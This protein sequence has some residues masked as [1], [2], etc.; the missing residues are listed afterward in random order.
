[1]S[2]PIR[3]MAVYGT[4]P[5]AVKMAPIIGALNADSGFS[6]DVVVTGQHR[7]ML[8]QINRAFG[9]VPRMDLDIFHHGQSISALAAKT[10]HGMESVLEC[11]RPD[12]VLVQGDTTSALA[13]GLAAFYGRVPVVHVEAGLRTP[14]LH[15]P[16]P[17]EGNR[18]LLTRIASLHLAA[19]PRN[20]DTLI[21]E[22]VNPGDIVVTGNPVIDAIRMA[23]DVEVHHADERVGAAMASGRPLI[24]VTAHRRE[25]WGKPMTGIAAAL[26]RIATAFPEVMLVFPM[27]ANPVVRDAFRPVLGELENVVLTEPLEYFELA[28]VLSCSR[29]VLTDSGG[30]QEEAPALGVPAVV[31]RE[32]TERS[33][34]VDAGTA[35]LVGTDPDRIFAAVEALLRAAPVPASAVMVRNPYGDGQAA[36][37]TVA[38]LAAYFG[39]GDRMPDFSGARGQC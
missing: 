21:G 17:E 24:L 6:C 39:I 11:L 9:V 27:H 29:L 23:V 14:T 18:R 31:L 26:H 16:F 4:R 3:V 32:E 28:R 33:E 35:V 7:D 20:R 38:A 36:A 37:R 12:A 2:T 1:M 10:L 5:E 34:G 8:D 19:T 30:I 15:S 25:S 22:G 13:A